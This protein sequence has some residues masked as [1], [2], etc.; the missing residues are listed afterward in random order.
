MALIEI[1]EVLL[2]FAL[3]LGQVDTK[4]STSGPSG[5]AVKA[6]VSSEAFSASVAVWVAFVLVQSCQVKSHFVGSAGVCNQKEL[7]LSVELPHKINPVLIIMP[8][9]EQFQSELRV[10]GERESVGEDLE[11]VFYEKYVHVFVFAEVEVYVPK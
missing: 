5:L 9:L 8:L 4:V 10:V 11:Y 2:A 1:V 6:S 7:V 3:L